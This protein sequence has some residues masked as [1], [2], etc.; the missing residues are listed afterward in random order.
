MRCR[1]WLP[2]RWSRRRSGSARSSR[3]PTSAIRSRSP[4]EL[5]TLDDLAGGRFTLGIGAGGLGWD[6]TILGQDP[7]SPRERADRFAE[8]VAL[9]DQLL[10][11][12][13]T[14]AAGRFYAADAVRSYPGC[15]Q[16]PRIPFA[17][18]ATGPRGMRLAA[19]HGAAWVTNGDRTHD[20]PPL[21]AAEGCRVVRE[22]MR[23]L[24]EACAAVGREPASLD[25]VVQTG[26]RLD[27]GLG[28][29]AMFADT[30]DAYTEIGVTDLVVHW[31]R[32]TEP[33]QGDP[34]ILERIAISDS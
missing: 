34:S 7:W 19:E 31:P 10:V 9:L 26:T 28:S 25:R 20:G 3:R 21:T 15:V 16:Q 17:V 2:P 6:A 12:P 13:V 24:D 30:K 27:P 5:I 18:A 4:R 33:Y 29:P 32:P 1:R 22:Q 14:T 8:F 23:R 11:G